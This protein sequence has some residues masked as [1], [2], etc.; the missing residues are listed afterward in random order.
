MSSATWEIS[1]LIWSSEPHGPI[2]HHFTLFFKIHFNVIQP[3]TLNSSKWCLTI[4]FVCIPDCVLFKYE[5]LL[6]VLLMFVCMNHNSSVSCVTHCKLDNLGM[7]CIRFCEFL[8]STS[9][10][11]ALWAT[12][13]AVQ[14]VSAALFSGIMG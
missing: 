13:P 5:Y 14:W 4:T 1:Y 2:L 12:Q 9:S 6:F 8:L 7:I 11:Q 3:S 10:R